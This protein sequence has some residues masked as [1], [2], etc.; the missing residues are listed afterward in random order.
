MRRTLKRARAISPA[1]KIIIMVIV[2]VI[3]VAVAYWLMVLLGGYA[4]T[5]Q[6]QITSTQNT[7]TST[8]TEQLQITSTQNTAT[9]TGTLS[10]VEQLQIISAQST[11]NSAGYVSIVIKNTGNISSKIVAIKIGGYNIQSIVDN[12]N[13][14]FDLSNGITIPAGQS[15]TIAGTAYTGNNKLNLVPGQVVTISVVTE[16]GKQ[17]SSAVVVGA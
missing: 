5:E 10:M 11:I 16:S 2:I 17:F 12:N 15:V 6:L 9:S 13:K 8:G 14:V 3:S 7:A 1:T 4:R